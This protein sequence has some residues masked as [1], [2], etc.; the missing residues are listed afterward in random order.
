VKNIKLLEKKWLANFKNSEFVKNGVF[1]TSLASKFFNG[2]DEENEHFNTFGN[3]FK[4]FNDNFD[5]SNQESELKTLLKFLHFIGLEVSFKAINNAINTG[6]CDCQ[7]VVKKTFYLLKQISRHSETLDINDPYYDNMGDLF[8]FLRIEQGESEE[9]KQLT[10]FDEIELPELYNKYIELPSGYENDKIAMSLFDEIESANQS[11]FIT[12][13]AGTGK[14]TFV[15]YFTKN[16]D[17]EIILLAFTGIASIN[18]SGQTI[19]SFFRFPFKPLLPN[20]EE[21]PLFR[22]FWQNYKIIEKAK[23]IIIDEVSMLRSDILEAIDCSLRKNGG[24]PN[25]P[26]GGKQMIFVGD[27]FQLP[28][29]YNKDDE[30]EKEVFSKIYKSEYFFDSLVYKSLFLNF[31]E[32]KK[33]HRQSNEH[34][35]HL[36]NKVRDCS[37]DENG[38]SLL[39]ARY[40]P[41]FSPEINDFVIMLSTNNFI[42]RDEN[43]QRIAS[44]PYT[45]HYFKAKITGDFKEDKYP[46]L[47]ILEL[48]KSSQV[49]FVKNDPIVNGRRWVNGTIGKVEFIADDDI[50]VKLKDGQIYKI[51]KEVWENRKYQWDKNKGK[52]TSKVIGEFEQFPL[53][54]AWA[55]TIHK[56]QG[57]TFDK[58][59][60]H[61]G[62][63]AFVNGQLYTALSRC[64]SLDGINLKRRIKKTDI[65]EDKRLIDFY[66]SL[67]NDTEENGISDLLPK[68]YTQNSEN[69]KPE[70]VKTEYKKLKGLKILGK[71]IDL[72]QFMKK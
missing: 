11:Y 61:T 69:Q 29:I 55:I 5:Y 54:L 21:I 9:E 18:I 50:E 27:I 22:D 64:R 16:S 56:S 17:K 63:G 14:S 65:I 51:S 38:I 59:N 4:N 44:L 35:I 68:D 13:K 36:L 33:V 2:F 40:N 41:D 46:T 39:N 57:L 15:H 25:L 34:F 8:F 71:K 66:K 48:K 67:V 72:S 28:P 19:H 10:M 20:D 60:L 47:P 3:G 12:G 7:K 53:K 31:F 37:I 70:K 49:M 43:R 45:S 26:F 32:F 42:A 30:V 58:I 23:T 24:N 1:N 62:T 6:Q 52:I